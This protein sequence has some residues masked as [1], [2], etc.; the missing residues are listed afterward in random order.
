MPD[1]RKL[2]YGIILVLTG[3][4][5]MVGLGG[6]LFNQANP[7]PLQWQHQAFNSLCHQMVDRSFWINGQ[8]M[9]VCS[10]CIGIYGGFAMGWMVLPVLSYYQVKGI[11]SIQK[12]V[13]LVLLLNI[14]DASGDFLDLWKNTLTSRLIL[15]SLLGG[16]TAMIFSGDF[17]HQ[18]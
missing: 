3:V 5:V 11:A 10:R 13:V 18:N 12:I 15:G 14:V 9:A 7:W 2:L 16:S 17:F 6:G 8:P 4:T 1:Q